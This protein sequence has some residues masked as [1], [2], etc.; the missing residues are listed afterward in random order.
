M[1]FLILSYCLSKRKDQV[2]EEVN[3]F[4]SDKTSEIFLLE[5]KSCFPLSSKYLDTATNNP[6]A[7]LSIRL[8]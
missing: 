4:Q 7:P 6:R 5:T 1:T 2:K 8:T 3:Y